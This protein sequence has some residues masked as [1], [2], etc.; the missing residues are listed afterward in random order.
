MKHLIGRFLALFCLVAA[1]P[2]V[3]A[4]DAAS[5]LQNIHGRS[6]LSLNGRWN[7]IIDP[8][9]NGYYDYRRMYK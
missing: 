5:L 1:T 2:S 7:Y 3:V 9:E 8:Y 4:Q 6:R